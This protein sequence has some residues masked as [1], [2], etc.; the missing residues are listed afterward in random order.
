MSRK[1]SRPKKEATASPK[2]AD[3]LKRISEQPQPSVPNPCS[4]CNFPIFGSH[5][6]TGD[7]SMKNGGSFAHPEC[8]WR[9]RAQL[10]EAELHRLRMET[11]R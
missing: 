8:Y 3:A 11:I 7:G 10:A 4:V 2:L 5:I 1:V 6:G 9:R